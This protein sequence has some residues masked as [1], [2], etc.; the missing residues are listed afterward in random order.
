M[1][2]KHNV[3]IAKYRETVD[4]AVVKALN[5]K[6][7][8]A[9]KYK[10]RLRGSKPNTVTSPYIRWAKCPLFRLAVLIVFP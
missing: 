8:A 1:K 10:I 4:P 5:K 9:G 3:D 2:E 7:A 6:L